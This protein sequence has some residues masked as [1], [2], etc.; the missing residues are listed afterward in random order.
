MAPVARTERTIS[1]SERG[2]CL[3]HQVVLLERFAHRTV[4]LAVAEGLHRWIEDLL[5]DRMCLELPADI[6]RHIGLLG[7]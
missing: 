2:H 5:L 1:F 4:E 7:S 6:L 3:L